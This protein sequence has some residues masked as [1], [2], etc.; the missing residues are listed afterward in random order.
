MNI[1]VDADACPKV[2]KEILFRAAL[3][4]QLELVLVANQP[5]A[6]PRQP[7]VRAVTV[8]QGFDVADKAIVEWAQAGDIVITNDVPLAAGAV[9][10]GALAISPRGQLWT[11][12]NVRQAL[13]LRNFLDELRGAGVQTG[14]PAAMDQRDRQAFAAQLDKLLAKVPARKIGA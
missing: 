8:P 1:Y 7:G 9:D 6:V 12:D 3:R 14:G 4:K 11:R 2:I 10:K 5:L 13:G